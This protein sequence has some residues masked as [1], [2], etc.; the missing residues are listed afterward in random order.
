MADSS[1]VGRRYPWWEEWQHLPWCKRSS[2]RSILAACAICA[3][4]EF[5]SEVMFQAARR[6]PCEI[7]LAM[8]RCPCELTNAGGPKL[9]VS[10]P[11]SKR[12][13]KSVEVV[14]DQGQTGRYA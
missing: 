14:N 13:C 4:I 11:I 8:F 2:G 5:Q 7:N 9:E 12:P 6:K 3:L 1:K 10:M